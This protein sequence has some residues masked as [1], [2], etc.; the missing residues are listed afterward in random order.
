MKTFG[1][2]IA[3]AR[4]GRGLTQRA[5]AAQLTKQDGATL[6]LAYINDIEH[7]RRNPPVAH[8]VGQLAAVLGV[9]HE[10]LRFYARRLDE[11]LLVGLGDPPHPRIVAAYAAF[12]R[13]LRG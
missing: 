9:P 5:L 12:K 7:N 10:V 13:E 8:F 3:E 2:I 4:K 11:E 6:C 1:E